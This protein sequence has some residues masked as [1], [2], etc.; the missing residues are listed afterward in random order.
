VVV[1]PG[2]FIFVTSVAFNTFSDALREAM[3][4]QLT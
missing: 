1:L 2:I 4:T 3:N